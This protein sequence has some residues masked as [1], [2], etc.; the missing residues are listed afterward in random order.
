MDETTP[1]MTTLFQQ[2]GLDESEQ[3]IATFIRQNQLP[4]DVSIVNA[5]YWTEA[6]RQFI[7]EQLAADAAWAIVVDQLNESLH[8]DAVKAQGADSSPA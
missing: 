7:S 1:R 4:A 6:Q 2:L 5:P 8:E 3:A